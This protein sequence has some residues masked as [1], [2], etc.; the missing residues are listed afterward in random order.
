MLVDKN[1]FYYHLKNRDYNFCIAELKNEII[2]ILILKIKEK[3]PE[4]MYTTLKSLKINCFEYLS[5]AEQ[6]VAIELYS[7][8][9]D[10]SASEYELSRMLELYSELI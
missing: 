10:N 3:N 9:Y 5:E 6:D 8:C 7:F 1:L 2:N 4:Y